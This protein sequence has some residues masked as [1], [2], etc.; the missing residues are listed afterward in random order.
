VLHPL[1]SWSVAGVLPPALK[2]SL[3]PTSDDGGTAMAAKAKRIELGDEERAELERVAR[4]G[5]SERRMVE[6]AQIVLGAA[7]GRS[8]K[9]IAEQVGCSLN[10]AKKW[11]ARF[12]EG[13]LRGLADKPRPGKPLV[14][15]AT[16]R[17]RLIAKAC[18]RP[19]DTVEGQRRE[20]WTY[21]EL[22]AEVGMAP[23]HAH[24]ILRAA[25]IKPH[26]TDYWVMSE[27]GPDFDAQAAEVCGLYL[28]PPENTIVL[29][30][31]EKTGIQAKAPTRPDALPKAGKP[32]R[33]EQ[34]YKRNGTQ[35]LFA[36]LEV[37][38]GEVAAMASKTRDRWDLLAFLELLDGGIPAGQE[39]IAIT[40]NLSTRT[41]QEVADWLEA[42][43]RWRFQFTPTHASWLNQVELFF[44]ILARR[45]LKHGT[46]GSEADLAEQMLCF[47]ETYN[48]TA[49]PFAWTYTGK[50]LSA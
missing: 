20:R 1:N 45:L 2:P 43:P 44:S 15:D 19:P 26:R 33:R 34:E 38:S 16:A 9:R 35:C 31:D 47:V 5:T 46:F 39:V 25:D 22:A 30:I 7:E 32:A 8:A 14:H 23:S 13:G 49:R 37:H 18:T 10:T 48:Q 41:T 11:R 24:Q 40:D 27:L 12:E 36:S 50:V 4:A 17:A 21:A 6:R 3:E 28:D 29:S 42:H